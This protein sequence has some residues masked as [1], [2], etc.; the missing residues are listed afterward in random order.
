[1]QAD[2]QVF[3]RASLQPMFR[4]LGH[5]SSVLELLVVAEKGWLISSS[6]ESLST[7]LRAVLTDQVPEMFG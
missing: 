1:M 3:S 5:E 7:R 2:A 4:L 6:S